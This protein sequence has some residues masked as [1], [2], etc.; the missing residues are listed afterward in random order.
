SRHAFVASFTGTAWN[1][2]EYAEL[3]IQCAASTPHIL[4]IDA[5]DAVEN[6]RQFAYDFE[7]IG[8]ALLIPLWLT[9]RAM[10]S[11]GI[12]VSLDGHGADELLGGY[13]RAYKQALRAQGSLVRS[14]LRTLDLART[15]LSLHGATSWETPTLFDLLMEGDPL[16]RSGKHLVDTS[17]EFAGR[18]I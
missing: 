18:A 17:V 7:T 3:S 10:R 16:L 4:P 1:E 8:E 13:G 11:A 5:A 9:Y 2:R 6:L 15:L 12:S 14:P